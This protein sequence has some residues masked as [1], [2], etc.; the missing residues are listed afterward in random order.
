MS[1][2]EAEDTT[3]ESDALNRIHLSSAVHH[4]QFHPT[5]TADP[6]ENCTSYIKSK[7]RQLLPP[8]V[9]QE[10][11]K[12]ANVQCPCP[13]ATTNTAAT[14]ANNS[15]N[16]FFGFT[17]LPLPVSFPSFPSSPLRRT[18]SEPT[19]FSGHIQNA[20]LHEGSVINKK[21]VGSSVILRTISDPTPVANL[22]TSD[23]CTPSRPPARSLCESPDTRRLKRMKE[24]LREMNQW[25]NQVMSED[26]EDEEEGCE[27]TPKDESETDTE[28]TPE[29]A[30]LVE[31]NGNCLV[32]HFRCP[33]G[34]GYQ[35]LLNG[36]NCYYKL[37]SF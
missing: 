19:Q 26:E 7:K 28:K 34:S 12:R 33:C 3:Y 5:T 27:N 29:E 14:A 17:A 37:T 23:A 32:L 21:E 2:Q 10:P 20:P 1:N 9:F 13:L 24:R 4:R 30:V 18:V 15:S 35:V 16:P 22:K 11:S 36:N 8:T 6:L 25:W 31:Q